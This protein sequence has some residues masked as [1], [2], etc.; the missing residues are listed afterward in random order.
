MNR[1]KHNISPINPN[2]TPTFLENVGVMGNIQKYKH[3]I[4]PENTQPGFDIAY[5]NVI[6]MTMIEV[7]I[8]A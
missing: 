5:G 7:K 4:S 6:F 8:C 1:Q 2:I 3:P